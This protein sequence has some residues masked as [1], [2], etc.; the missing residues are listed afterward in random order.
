MIVIQQNVPMCPYCSAM[1]ST[2]HQRGN[3]YYFCHDCLKIL[4]VVD[5]GQAEIELLVTDGTDK[6]ESA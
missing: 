6:E 5:N 1:M 3:L 4:Q 2:R